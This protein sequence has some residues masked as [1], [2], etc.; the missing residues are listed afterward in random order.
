M[1]PTEKRERL[2][3]IPCAVCGDRSSGKHYG[4][5]SCD[6][7][8]GFFK[9]SIHRNRIYTCRAQAEQHGRCPVDKTH[10]NQCRACRLRKCFEANMNKEVSD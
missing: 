2:L 8:S 4:I 5:F 10:R 9:R 1:R 3:D 6:G 7:C